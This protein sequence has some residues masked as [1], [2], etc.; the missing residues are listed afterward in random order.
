V[1]LV[2]GANQGVELTDS[3]I[4]MTYIHNGYVLK[5]P[6]TT[7]SKSE[8]WSGCLLTAGMTLLANAAIYLGFKKIK[9]KKNF[10]DK[11]EY[12]IAFGYY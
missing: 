11:S 7:V 2:V 3:M 1:H 5:I 4:V 8:S 9:K 6:I 12:S 10:L